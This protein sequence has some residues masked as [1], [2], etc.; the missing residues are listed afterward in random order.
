MSYTAPSADPSELYFQPPVSYLAPTNL[1]DELYF[2]DATELLIVG[3]RF[4]IAM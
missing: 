3:S 1:L 2:D 4:F